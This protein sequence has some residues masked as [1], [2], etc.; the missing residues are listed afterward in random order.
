MILPMTAGSVAHFEQIAGFDAQDLT[1]TLQEVQ[2]NTTRA[3]VLQI[4]DGGLA[5][6]DELGQLDLGQAPFVPE[7]LDAEL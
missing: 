2:L 5:D 7:G 1:Q 3:I 4:I 6:A